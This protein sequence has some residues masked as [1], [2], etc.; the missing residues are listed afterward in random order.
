MLLRMPNRAELVVHTSLRTS[1]AAICRSVS[2]E[3]RA[4]SFAAVFYTVMAD[5]DTKSTGNYAMKWSEEHDR[6][7]C[8]EV[9]VLEPWKFPKQSKERG[10]VWGEVALRLNGTNYPKFKVSKRSVRERLTLLVNKYKEKTKKEE[11][12]SGI[13][14]DDETELEKALSEIIEK[15]QAADLERKQNSNT[16]TKKNESDKASAEESRLKAM[17]R[18]GQTKKRNADASSDQVTPPKSRK[19]TTEAA[20]ILKEKYENEKEIRKEEME[21]KKKEQENRAAEQQMLMDQQRHSQ[22]QYQDVLKVMTEQQQRQE[23]QMQNFQML[24]LQQQQQQSQVL[25][26]LLERVLPKSS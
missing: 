8:T 1:F 12:G 16:L 3:E 26:G 19:S 21:I 4:L 24:F 14:C 18:L 2:N 23:Q 20:Q 6:M 25:M 7:L 10:E 15:D 5:D 11:Q 9:L 13:E 22:Q 17:E